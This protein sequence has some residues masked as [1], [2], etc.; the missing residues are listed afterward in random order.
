LE[1]IK[2]MNPKKVENISSL[3]P[4][5]RVNYMV[6]KICDFEK[7]WGLNNNGWAKAISSNGIIISPFWPEDI[8]AAKCANEMWC[9]YEAKSIE[10]D[11]FI[12]RWLPGM[13]AD[14]VALALFP[15]VGHEGLIMAPD[16]FKELLNEELQQY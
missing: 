5:D 4:A 9:E 12:D 1:D 6:R 13:K 7:I 14:G 8:F 16:E 2:N 11:Y 15:I 10:L 3:P